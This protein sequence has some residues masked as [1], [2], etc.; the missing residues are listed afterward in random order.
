[1]GLTSQG[2]RLIPPPDTCSRRYFRCLSPRHLV[3]NCLSKI[4]CLFCHNYGHKAKLCAKRREAFNLKWVQRT[5]KPFLIVVPSNTVAEPVIQWAPRPNAPCDILLPTV[6]IPIE[7]VPSTPLPSEL[8]APEP[9]DPVVPG[10]AQHMAQIVDHVMDDLVVAN[11][12]QEI[13]EEDRN[14]GVFH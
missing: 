13:I 14:S 7:H 9:R 2:D 11:Q 4:G 1:M 6:P 8:Q 12:N 3:R 5:S 10:E